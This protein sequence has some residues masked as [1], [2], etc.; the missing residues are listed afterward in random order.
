MESKNG[1]CVVLYLGPEQESRLSE[2]KKQRASAPWIILT[3]RY[4]YEQYSHGRQMANM[5]KREVYKH[6]LSPSCLCP[7]I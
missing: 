6:K 3:Q 4:L 1:I 5:A 2:E 7:R